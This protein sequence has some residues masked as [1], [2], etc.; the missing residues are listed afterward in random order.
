MLLFQVLI[1][2]GGMDLDDIPLLENIL[3][4]PQLPLPSTL[5]STNPTNSTICEA[6]HSH[7][8]RYWYFSSVS[9]NSMDIE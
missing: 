1:F 4:F 8:F 7:R 2:Q 9:K 6:N 5:Y 3:S